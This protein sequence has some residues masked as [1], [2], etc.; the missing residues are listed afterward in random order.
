MLVIGGAG[1]TVV[2]RKRSA[3][4]V[5]GAETSVTSKSSKF[6]TK[7]GRHVGPLM[8]RCTAAQQLLQRGPHTFIVGARYQSGEFETRNEIDNGFT[9]PGGT[10]T[11]PI[12]GQNAESDFERLGAYG[13]YHWQPVDSLVLIGGVAYDRITFP[14]NHRFAPVSGSSATTLLNGV[15]RYSAPSTTSGVVSKPLRRRPPDSS[16]TSPV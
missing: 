16:E 6:A 12:R 7:A 11:D 5:L 4:G 3:E 9:F 1:V 13:Y 14:L 15:V 10:P 2:D 8:Y